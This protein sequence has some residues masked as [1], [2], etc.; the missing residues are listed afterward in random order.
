MP[1]SIRN[2]RNGGGWIGNAERG[3]AN[4]DEFTFEV[5]DAGEHIIRKDITVPR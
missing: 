3:N 5:S 4:V 2:D 1:R